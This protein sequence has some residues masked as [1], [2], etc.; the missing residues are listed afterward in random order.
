ME[1]EESAM[2]PFSD[3][4]FLGSSPAYSLNSANLPRSGQ[5]AAD[6]TTACSG[7]LHRTLAYAFLRMQMLLY[8]VQTNFTC[9]REH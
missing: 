6:P 3:E 5:K 1:S 2:K 9:K 8:N 4:Y 7:K